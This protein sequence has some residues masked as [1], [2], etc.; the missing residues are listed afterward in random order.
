M[1]VEAHEAA[2]HDEDGAV[3]P[4]AQV[5]EVRQ[6]RAIDE[7][8]KPVQQEEHSCDHDEDEGGQEELQEGVERLQRVVFVVEVRIRLSDPLPAEA[9]PEKG[10]PN[11]QC[12]WYN[13]AKSCLDLVQLVRNEE[14]PPGH[15]ILQRLVLALFRDRVFLTLART[16]PVQ[17]EHV[18]PS[19]LKDSEEDR[20][21][22]R[23]HNGDEEVEEESVG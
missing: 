18:S 5:S 22:P 10:E 17:N 11:Q 15:G 14:G 8:V 4:R 12:F 6:R 1:D 3:G 21:S 9:D 16:L 13:F 23:D 19:L 7:T 2:R 20:E